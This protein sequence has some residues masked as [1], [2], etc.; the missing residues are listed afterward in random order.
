MK[1]TIAIFLILMMLGGLAGTAYA[2]YTG[3]GLAGNPQFSMRS[4]SSGGIFFMGGGPGS[5]K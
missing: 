2:G 5:G 3:M 4:G 1:Q